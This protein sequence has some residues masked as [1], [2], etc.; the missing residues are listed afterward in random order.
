MRA[1]RSSWNCDQS[2]VGHTSRLMQHFDHSIGS[3]SFGARHHESIP[4]RLDQTRD[5]QSHRERGPEIRLRQ[6]RGTYPHL[7]PILHQPLQLSCAWYPRH[8]STRREYRSPLLLLPDQQSLV[9]KR[10]LEPPSSQ[11]LQQNRAWLHF[12]WL[13]WSRHLTYYAWL[14][15]RDWYFYVYW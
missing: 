4:K 9:Q 3:M 14:I 7:L 5:L 6:N 13:A 10:H 2:P 15:S 1:T 11:R 12:C 8:F